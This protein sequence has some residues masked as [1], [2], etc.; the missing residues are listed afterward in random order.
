MLDYKDSIIVLFDPIMIFLFYS[1]KNDPQGKINKQCKNIANFL[2][3]TSP[4]TN[5]KELQLITKNVS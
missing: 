4:K 1:L 5:T 2:T 3:H